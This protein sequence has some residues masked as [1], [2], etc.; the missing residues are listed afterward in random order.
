MNLKNCEVCYDLFLETHDNENVCSGCGKIDTLDLQ[1]IK[2][3]LRENPGATIFEIQKQINIS[4]DKL[5]RF[6]REGRI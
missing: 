3:Y 2:Q 1:K 4:S 6:K 5:L